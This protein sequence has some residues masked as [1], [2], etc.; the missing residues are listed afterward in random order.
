MLHYCQHRSDP[1]RLNRLFRPQSHLQVVRFLRPPWEPPG[2]KP[3]RLLSD[4]NDT[5]HHY[6]QLSECS[7]KKRHPASW[8]FERT[9]SRKSHCHVSATFLVFTSREDSHEA[10]KKYEQGQGNPC[11]I[12]TR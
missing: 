9:V 8:L 2:T 12:M 5:A 1:V 4:S 6:T 11:P 7:L 10:T 3:V